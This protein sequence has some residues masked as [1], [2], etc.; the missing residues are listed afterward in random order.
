[1][2]AKTTGNPTLRYNP[3][4]GNFPSSFSE[5]AASM[6]VSIGSRIGPYSVVDRLGEGGM[7]VVWKAHDSVLARDV[8][9]KAVRGEDADAT[10]RL[11][12]E[13]RLAARLNHPNVVTIHEVRQEGP[14]ACIVMEWIQG[15]PLSERI[16]PGGLPFRAAFA[17]A[18]PVARA[19]EAA[20]AAGIIHRDLKP[21]N[22]MVSN[23]GQVKLLDFGIAKRAAVVTAAS[24]LT[25]EAEPLSAATAGIVGT[26]PYMSPEQ[27]TG[28]PIDA[29]TD[30]FSFGVLLHELLT[31]QRPFTGPDPVSTMAAV[32]KH[33][34][35][36]IAT[37]GGEPVP[38][39]VSGLLLRC[40]RKDPS[41]RFQTT[42]DLRAALE[43]LA[44]ESGRQPGLPDSRRS[45]RRW[46]AAA[47]VAGVAAAAG[48]VVWLL[49]APSGPP[50]LVPLQ[51]ITFDPG[52]A[53]TP[54][55]SPDGRLL[56]FAS[57]RAESGNLDLWLRQAAGG[58]PARLT[59]RAGPEWNP[60][61]SPDGTR[62]LYL[63]GDQS[64]VE[65]PALGVA[66]QA[67]R[68]IVD[69]AGPFSASAN[70]DIAFVRLPQPSRLGPMFILPAGSTS[71]EPWQ[72]DCRATGRPVWSPE[73]D[74]LMFFGDCGETRGAFWWAPRGAG[75]LTPVRPPP[76]IRPLIALRNIGWFHHRGDDGV[77]FTTASAAGRIA[78]MNLDGD[79]APVGAG[80]EAESFGAAGPRGEIVLGQIEG[81]NGIWQVAPP[82]TEAR[83]VAAAIGH[84]AV[85]RDGGTVIFGRLTG[86]T[87]GELVLRDL[88]SGSERVFASH[89][90][91]SVSIGSIWPQVSPDRRQIVYRVVGQNGGHYVLE[92]DTGSVRRLASLEAFQLGSDW[93]PDSRAIL[94]ECAAP[95]FGICRMDPT[96]GAI[97]PLFV[98][99]TDQLLYPSWSPDGRWIT[100][101]R[102]RPGGRST[103]WAAPLARP[104]AMASE[105]RWVQIS[106]AGPDS[107]RPRFSLD[108]SAVY[109]VAGADGVR[110]LMRQAIDR[111]TLA[112]DGAP[113]DT[114]PFPVEVMVVTGGFGPYPLIGVTE[115]G[116]FFSTIA[117]RGNLFASRL[118]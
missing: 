26:T 104:D 117:R 3:A 24:D 116:V 1:L 73:G 90:S 114:L 35:P 103:I 22:A 75:A 46:I 81:D 58:S 21:S 83:R 77:L 15:R 105:D 31:G 2:P 64:I 47:A 63:S 52:I 37:A 28:Q 89:D 36:A 95:G 109:Y 100:F 61:F 112:P 97:L 82:S 96:T 14:F 27:I 56:A 57:D 4:T 53:I 66:G 107:Q 111:K 32:L 39:S 51:Q 101:G 93:S 86:G 71:P 12:R 94:G 41:R 50:Q 115:K 59:T 69:D 49:P 110:R 76:D 10:A 30:I 65:I 18:I 102:R 48:G 87:S 108:M 85:T 106:A 62:L 16:T 29:R 118:E 80:V 11:V 33:E 60:Q 54:A 45:S 67:P 74:R 72:P 92:T 6:D 68:P 23:T 13:A 9:I 99:Q 78:W 20:H 40:L 8:A 17:L 98:D 55:F 43:D 84:F 38:P 42:A 5:R 91:I 44:E 7:G 88:A 79:A 70:G 34:P 19:L 25:T 113:V